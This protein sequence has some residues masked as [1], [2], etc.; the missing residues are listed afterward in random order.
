MKSMS[1]PERESTGAD[2]T[3]R[4]HQL[5]IGKTWRPT[6]GSLSTGAA[7]WTTAIVQ[8]KAMAV[9][10]VRT[11]TPIGQSR[12]VPGR[13]DALTP[14]ELRGCAIRDTRTEVKLRARM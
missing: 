10:G 13:G 4:F 8:T 14:C 11:D 6:S 7:A 1:A 2:V 9:S 5:L 12:T 3:S